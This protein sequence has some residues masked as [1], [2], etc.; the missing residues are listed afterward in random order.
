MQK[1]ENGECGNFFTDSDILLYFH[2]NLYLKFLHFRFLCYIILYYYLI[3]L[4]SLLYYIFIIIN[5]LRA[6][7]DP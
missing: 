4:F 2:Y 5:L 7:P 3:L 6:S 1:A